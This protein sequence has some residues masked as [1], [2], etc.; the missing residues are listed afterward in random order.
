MNNKCAYCK[1][2]PRESKPKTA[3]IYCTE[4]R[5]KMAKCEIKSVLFKDVPKTLSIPKFEELFAHQKNI[6]D[7]N[8]LKCGLFLG[9]GG[10]KTRIALEMAE[11]RTL[12]ITPKQQFLDKTWERNADR[13]SI[14]LNMTVM[15]K[16]TFRRDWDTLPYYDTIIVDEAHTMFGATPDTTI[17]KGVPTP[18]LSQLFESLFK[19]IQKHPPKRFYPCTAT[20]VS[21]PMNVWAIARLMGYDWDFFK[22]RE[23]H[24]FQKKIGKWNRWLP[25]GN[26]D[27]KNK[28]AEIVK[29]FGYTGRLSDWFD[30]PEQTHITKYVF[31]TNEQKAAIEEVRKTQADPLVKRAKIRTIENGILYGR[32]IT[33]IGLKSEKLIKT[34]KHFDSEKI[35]YILER[36]EEFPK[37]LI[38]ANYIAQI[39]AISKALKSNGYNV[40]VLTGASNDRNTIITDA[41]ASEK[42]IVV[43]QCGISSGYE[44]KTFDCV[45]FASKNYQYLHYDQGVGRVL[46]ADALKKNLYIHL[47]VKND[48]KVNGKIVSS[49]DES[50]HETILSGQDFQEKIY[51]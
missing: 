34:I 30:V 49:V 19:F 31:L 40:K 20:P 46:R 2:N 33:Q 7:A 26:P 45:I 5:L 13:F 18:K 4:C 16:E 38:F 44:L 15:S 35:D 24:Y 1:L 6:I 29:R 25:R 9:T 47:V 28:L 17:I 21:K 12:I 41:D 11:G 42:C 8:T 3:G 23:K 22:F 27:L 14:I 50:C 43:A 32:D 37:I 48:E 51:E 10:G 39:E 36:A